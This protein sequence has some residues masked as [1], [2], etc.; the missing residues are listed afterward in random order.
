MYADALKI[1]AKTLGSTVNNVTVVP[2]NFDGS[3][4]TESFCRLTVV[5]D[6]TIISEMDQT[7]IQGY[8]NI[9]IYV[10]AGIGQ[11][12]TMQTCDAIDALLNRQIID[13]QIGFGQ[14]RVT[15][16]GI[17]AENPNLYRT[18]YEIDFNYYP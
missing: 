18:D 10:A 9:S 5:A 7:F 6:E 14:S 2:D 8:V 4:A 12:E 16:I 13:S 3:R 17:D 1:I 15:P 11:L